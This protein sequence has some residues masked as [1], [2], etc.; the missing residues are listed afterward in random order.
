[1]LSDERA[2]GFL[3]ISVYSRSA[4]ALAIGW[5]QAQDSRVE[6]PQRGYSSH[7]VPTTNP[8]AFIGAGLNDTN[9][10]NRMEVLEMLRYYP[11][12]KDSV[13]ALIETIMSSPAPDVR[14]QIVR[15]M[16]QERQ[17]LRFFIQLIVKAS[18]SRQWG[19]P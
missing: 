5:L 7:A 8:Q 16:V 6:T 2:E 4:I 3:E 11:N 19:S 18:T 10:L 15:F 1:M 14:E 13:D 9:P 17:D 12:T